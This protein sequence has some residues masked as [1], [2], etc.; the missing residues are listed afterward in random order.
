[1]H[2]LQLT[3]LAYPFSFQL[4]VVKAPGQKAIATGPAKEDAS[5]E[6]PDGDQAEAPLNPYATT[7]R[8]RKRK[9]KA[10]DDDLED[11]YFRRLHEDETMPKSKKKKAK[12]KVGKN[13]ETKATGKG[14]GDRGGDGDGSGYGSGGGSG[15]GDGDGTA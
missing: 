5:R 15:D 8:S 10:V 6:A 12:A 7:D 1:M 2:T 4:G 14:E 13:A 11:T 3:P 9:R